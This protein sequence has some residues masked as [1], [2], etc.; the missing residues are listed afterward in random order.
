MYKYIY[1]C[2]Y[3]IVLSQLTTGSYGHTHTYMVIH[4]ASTCAQ[5]KVCKCSEIRYC[6]MSMY[7]LPCRYDVTMASTYLTCVRT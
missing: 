6:P 5:Q 4:V 7:I 2:I 3:H 1:I